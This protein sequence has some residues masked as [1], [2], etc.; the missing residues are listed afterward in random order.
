MLLF[1]PLIICIG[2]NTWETLLCFFYLP[3]LNKQVYTSEARHFQYMCL[4]LANHQGLIQQLLSASASH[5]QHEK[6]KEMCCHGYM[7]CHLC[8]RKKNKKKTSVYLPPLSLPSF[9]LFFLQTSQI[10]Q[11]LVMPLTWAGSVCYITQVVYPPRFLKRVFIPFQQLRQKIMM[12]VRQGR[13]VPRRI[14]I[15]VVP[16]V[17]SGMAGWWEEEEEGGGVVCE[18]RILLQ[19]RRNPARSIFKPIEVC[20]TLSA[21]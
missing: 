14:S 4:P 5:Y 20:N 17:K 7:V 11:L 10:F 8:S 3:H 12:Q 6:V 18:A 21:L 1:P 16:A 9:T 19:W 13:S 2:T 15:Q